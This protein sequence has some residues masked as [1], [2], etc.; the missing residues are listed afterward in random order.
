MSAPVRPTPASVNE[1]ISHL[2]KVIT[3]TK[4]QRVTDFLQSK[5]L[6]MA[7]FTQ[8][9]EAYQSAER[10]ENEVERFC[11]MDTVQFPAIIHICFIDTFKLQAHQATTM[12]Q[13]MAHYIQ[14]LI[15]IIAQLKFAL[16]WNKHDGNGRGG[17][18]GDHKSKLVAGMSKKQALARIGQFNRARNARNVC[19]RMYQIVSANAEL[20]F[21]RCGTHI[22]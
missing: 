18:K 7:T 5:R 20:L 13:G 19:L 8:M 6:E 4:V 10:E 1:S 21:L 17:W 22:S 14:T 11:K 12:G 15:H 9:L 2:F 16:W 3:R